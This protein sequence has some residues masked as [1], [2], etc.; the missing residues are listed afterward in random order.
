M[1][2]KVADVIMGRSFSGG[3]SEDNN[4]RVQRVGRTVVQTLTGAPPN[5]KSEGQVGVMC[6]F[7]GESH[8]AP[9]AG[10]SDPRLLDKLMA[11]Q[12]MD[13]DGGR[14][15]GLFAVIE[16]HGGDAVSTFVRDELAKCVH[17]TFQTVVD[18]GGGAAGAAA[19]PFAA[20]AAA[21][22]LAGTEA[23]LFNVFL[24]LDRRLAE[25]DEKVPLALKMSQGA[26][27]AVA[28]VRD[29]TLYVANV[30]D[31]KAA[32]LVDG[33]VKVLTTRHG[34]FNAA[35]VADAGVVAAFPRSFGHFSR[36]PQ[37]GGVGITAKPS[38]SR[39]QLSAE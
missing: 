13:R 4:V 6:T 12:L 16:G 17:D 21:L 36:K 39:T 20:E 28:L 29:R 24:E 5:S 22:D 23:H 30:G 3:Y 32:M 27:A 19:L 33:E 9:Y 15:Q 25:N 31:V 8:A 34:P 14:A 7:D 35:D 18:N 11:A 37:G 2:P 38:V 1:P 26:T 10:H